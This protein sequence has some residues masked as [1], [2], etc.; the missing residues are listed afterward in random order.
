MVKKK[1]LFM[2]RVRWDNL[3]HFHIWMLQ[4]AETASLVF[5]KQK[6]PKILRPAHLKLTIEHI[7]SGLFNPYKTLK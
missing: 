7:N 4:L 5:F 1:I 2:P 3:Y 6:K